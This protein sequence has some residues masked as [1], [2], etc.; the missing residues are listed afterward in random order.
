MP[1]RRLTL[2]AVSALALA[3]IALGVLAALADGSGRHAAPVAPRTPRVVAAV[4]AAAPAAVP[5]VP[6]AA[7]RLRP[8]LRA[9][10]PLLVAAA[11]SSRY[12]R[13]YAIACGVIRIAGPVGAV[14]PKP[15][16]VPD[17]LL[18][19]FGILR[20]A[21]TP[22]DA[23]P[24]DA[25]Q[26]LRI[27]GLEPFDPAAA[28]LVRTTP[29][30]GRAWVVPTRDVP[31]TPGC[32]VAALV[33]PAV[34]YNPKTPTPLPALPAPVPAT[35]TRPAKPQKATPHPGLALV[36]LGGAPVGAG[37]RYEDL[38][39]GREDVALDPCGGPGHDMLSVS[40]LVP[41]GVPAAFLTSPDGT[42][43]RA[44]VK[45]NAYTF[46]VPRS[47]RAETRYVVWT[48]GDGTPHVQPLTPIVYP[49][50]SSCARVHPVTARI[51]EISPRATTPILPAPVAV[52]RLPTLPR[53]K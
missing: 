15:E 13:P 20:R 28:R 21:A 36:A 30:G 1:S 46:V 45:D 38:I 18:H 5:A 7:A 23:L 34:V 42:A 47:A 27:R 14:A 33:P 43:I 44:D 51:P 52:K 25:L 3:C 50:T 2:P 37:G 53:H 11:A 17:D 31:N 6:V 41:D 48:G 22:D 10:R 12:L 35:P 49:S 24:K 39:R 32:G 40:G 29:D 4:P 16:P 8:A 26:A 19:A 9:T